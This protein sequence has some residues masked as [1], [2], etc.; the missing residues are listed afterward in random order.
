MPQIGNDNKPVILKSGQRNKKRIL[1]MTGSFYVGEN[2]KNYDEN[3]NRIFKNKKL[4]DK[5]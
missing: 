5:E 2:K 4:G 3:Y 1:G